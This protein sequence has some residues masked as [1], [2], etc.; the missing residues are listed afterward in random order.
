MGF[1]WWK[2]IALCKGAMFVWLLV[3]SKVVGWQLRF[4][5]CSGAVTMK[6]M[7]MVVSLY[8]PLVLGS[9]EYPMPYASCLECCGVL[10]CCVSLSCSSACPLV[11]SLKELCLSKVL[12]F[13]S[14]F[15]LVHSHDALWDS[16]S[17]PM[18][19]GIACLALQAPD[20]AFA[21]WDG[22]SG[23]W[24]VGLWLGPTQVCLL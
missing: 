23:L 3:I 13:C 10:L 20:W 15:Y 14:L 9:V 11:F 1:F 18:P 24:L 5:H 2:Y 12:G 4:S 21:F 8:Y 6:V 16:P 22:L 7:T 17:R 19:S